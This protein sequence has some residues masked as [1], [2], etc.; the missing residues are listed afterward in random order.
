MSDDE[1]ASKDAE[2]DVPE[3]AAEEQ[4]ADEQGSVEKAKDQ[5]ETPEFV[6]TVDANEFRSSIVDRRIQQQGV[7]LGESAT[8]YGRVNGSITMSVPLNEDVRKSF[9]SK[10]ARSLAEIRKDLGVQNYPT[11]YDDVQPEAVDS[12]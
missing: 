8:Y 3:P 4:A 7:T 10:A 1:D 2:S 6:I 5:R 9:L 11:M 12:L